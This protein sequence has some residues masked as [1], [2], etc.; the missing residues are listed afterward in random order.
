MTLYPPDDDFDRDFY[1][2]PYAWHLTEEA[3]EAI[4]NTTIS[5]LPDDQLRRIIYELRWHIRYN[6]Q[7]VSKA[8]HPTK[9]AF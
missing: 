7:P 9:G 1:G 2:L 4:H 6:T 3:H 8:D 5:D